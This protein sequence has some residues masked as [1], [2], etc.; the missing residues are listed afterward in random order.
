[1]K[2]NYHSW[3]HEAETVMKTGRYYEKISKKGFASEAVG[4]LPNQID[5]ALKEFYAH[6]AEKMIEQA[7]LFDKELFQELKDIKYQVAAIIKDN[8]ALEKKLEKELKNAQLQTQTAQKQD[9]TQGKTLMRLAE[10]RRGIDESTTPPKKL[11]KINKQLHAAK[12]NAQRAR[13]NYEKQVSNL[14]SIDSRYHS[15]MKDMLDSMQKFDEERLQKTK[16]IFIR[17]AEKQAEA[18]REILTRAEQL[19]ESIAHTSPDETVQVFIRDNKT[20]AT[21]PAPDTFQPYFSE[22][23]KMDELVDQAIGSSNGFASTTPSTPV[24]ATAAGNSLSTRSSLA[25][26]VAPSIEEPQLIKKVKAIY[27]YSPEKSDEIELME[28]DIVE[29]YRQ[30][31][32]GWWQGKNQRTNKVGDFPSNFCEEFNEPIKKV[33]PPPPP[34][35]T[36]QNSTEKTRSK[37]LYDYDAQDPSELSFKEGDELNIIQFFD[38]G[39]VFAESAKSGQRGLCPLNYTSYEG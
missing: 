2:G 33:T 13:V 35:A 10:A 5:D 14:Q 30:N 27:E 11:E 31:D 4:D 17:Y 24:S 20:T 26:S 3:K 22:A 29:V 25:L 15:E 1:M 28:G 38:D 6:V 37:A 34:V 21:R 19:K 23:S 39:W 9:E 12:E 36:N 8:T 7:N 16:D 32:D 18:A